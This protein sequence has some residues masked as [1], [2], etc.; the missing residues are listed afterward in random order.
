MGA[1]RRQAEPDSRAVNEVFCYTQLWLPGYGS[2]VTGCVT[3]LETGVCE[4]PLQQKL[5]GVA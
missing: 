2:E 1:G 5:S 4:S 3:M